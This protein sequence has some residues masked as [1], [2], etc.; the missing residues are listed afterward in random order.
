[1]EID[2]SKA[3]LWF[4]TGKQF[5]IRHKQVQSIARI[6]LLAMLTG[7]SL[8][9]DAQ[10]DSS[11]RD[12]RGSIVESGSVGALKLRVGDCYNLPEELLAEAS[13]T[14]VS[15]D[16]GVSE[17]AFQFS[18]LEGVPCS[19]PHDAE[20]VGAIFLPPVA[21][22]PGIDSIRRSTKCSE[23][24]RIYADRDL[25]QSSPFKLIF[26]FPSEDAWSRAGDR[27]IHCLVTDRE[28]GKLTKSVRSIGYSSAE[29]I[30]LNLIRNEVTESCL[31]LVERTASV[32]AL[33]DLFPNLSN[34]QLVELERSLTDWPAEI[35]RAI[36]SL[37]A[38]AEIQPSAIAESQLKL[39]ADEI[40]SVPP[41]DADASSPEE[42]RGEFAKIVDF[43]QRLSDLC[44][45]TVKSQ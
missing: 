7:C 29:L 34:S 39:F 31:N 45:A 26:K 5:A 35:D 9:N 24:F 20:A 22:Y 23:K 18:S 15:P 25:T 30:D 36:E 12:K 17:S 13:E 19:E 16:V 40:D 32:G 28:G 2:V 41:T 27:V 1:L 4:R 21:Q 6:A 3:Q 11:N 14:T 37:A 33:V 8:I 44:L 43:S 38:L 10:E 42:L